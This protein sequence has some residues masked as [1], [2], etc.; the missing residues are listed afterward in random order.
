MR[1]T[2]R[3]DF[4]YIDK[5]RDIYKQIFTYSVIP[6]L[7]H[8]MEMNILNANDSAVELFGFN[9]DE[10]LK[11]K[12]SELHTLDEQQHS[13]EV[14]KSMRQENRLSVETSF[15][16]KDGSVFMAE[17]TPCKYII[18]QE[19]IIHVFIQ[20]ITERK[21]AERQLLESSL[22]LEAEVAKVKRYTKEIE[23]K[24]KELEDF[25]YVAAHDLKAPITNLSILSDM[26]GAEMTPDQHKSPVFI[27]LRKNIDQ[28]HNKVFALNDVINFKATLDYESEELGFQNIFEEVTIGISEQFKNETIDIETDFSECPEIKYPKI[29]LKS[30]LQNLLTNAIKFKDPDRKL[31]I[32]LKTS[33]KQDNVCLLI[34]DNGL[35]FEA[36]KYKDKIYKLFKRLH[37]HVEGM[38]VGMYIVKSIVDSHGGK[39]DVTSKPKEGTEFTIYLNNVGL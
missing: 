7:V 26:V 36:S 21:L 23:I 37:I 19:P 27:N 17:A 24:N 14:L 35:G 22:A 32:Q 5:E 15:K 10:L 6:I 11:K 29:H 30:I 13:T 38:G 39:I 18:D 28:I 9:Y 20:D 8:D 1:E 34:K 3:N 25:S 4:R 2:K 33:R 16:R 31:K 12:V